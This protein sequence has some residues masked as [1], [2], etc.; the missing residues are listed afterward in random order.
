MMMGTVEKWFPER[1][2]GFITRDDTGETIFAH[3]SAFKPEPIAIEIGQRVEFA[4]LRD[5]ASGRTK[6]QQVKL[7]EAERPEE[8]A[9]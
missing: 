9:R 3:I 7:I 4:I 8:R 6:A 2:Y 5:S 1:S